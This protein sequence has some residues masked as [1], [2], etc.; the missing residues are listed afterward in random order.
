M[1]LQCINTKIAFHEINKN[2]RSRDKRIGTQE[3]KVMLYRNLLSPTPIQFL[4]WVVQKTT[5]GSV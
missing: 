5:K 1:R 4:G 2:I 3:T